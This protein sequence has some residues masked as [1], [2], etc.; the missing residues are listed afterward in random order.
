MVENRER[1]RNFILKEIGEKKN[2]EMEKTEKIQ[3]IIE[4]LQLKDIEIDETLRI[5]KKWMENHD[6]YWWN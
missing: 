6:Q 1:E 3:N 5:G 4:K 2:E